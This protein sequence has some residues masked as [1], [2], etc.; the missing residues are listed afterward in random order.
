M[1]RT[2]NPGTGTAAIRTIRAS[3]TYSTPTARTACSTCIDSGRWLPAFYG[4]SKCRCI[5]S[6]KAESAARYSIIPAS[7]NRNL[8]TYSFLQESFCKGFCVAT[9][10]ASASHTTGILGISVPCTSAAHKEG[11]NVR[12]LRD[13]QHTT[14]QQLHHAI[15]K[16]FV[17]RPGV[18]KL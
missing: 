17:V 11:I 16:A 2:A 13:L 8:I 5:A 18:L 1:T 12:V 10:T 9:S 6:P 7:T 3:F 14:G 15:I 4:I